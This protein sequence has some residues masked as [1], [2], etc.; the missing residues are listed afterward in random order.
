MYE[1]LISF[2]GK[3]SMT[4]GEVRELTDPSAIKDLLRAGY[5]KEVTKEPKRGRPRKAN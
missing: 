3:V 5:I 4:V 2:S 1:A